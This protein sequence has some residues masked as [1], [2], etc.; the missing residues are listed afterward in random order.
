M[1]TLIFTIVA[2]L[3]SS[4]SV[5]ALGGQDILVDDLPLQERYDFDVAATDDGILFAVC[6]GDETHTLLSIYRSADGGSKWTHWSDIAPVKPSAEFDDV[7]L[8]VTSG[9][10]GSLLVAWVEMGGLLPPTGSWLQVAKSEAVEESPVWSIQEVDYTSSFAMGSLAMSARAMNGVPDRVSLAWKIDTEIS[11]AKSLTAGSLWQAPLE[12]SS[13]TTG[14][15]NDLDVAADDLGVVHLT[16]GTVDSGS[17][18]GL[19]YYCRAVNNGS[20]VTSWGAPQLLGEFPPAFATKVAVAANPDG[21]GVVVAASSDDGLALVTS[22]NA[23]LSWS[24]LQEYPGLSR[25]DADWGAA[26]PFVGVDSDASSGLGIGRAVISPIAGFTGAWAAELMMADTKDGL[27][28]PRLAV[29]PSRGG[30]PMLACVNPLIGEL[31]DLRLWFDAA[32]RDVPGYGVPE[33]MFPYGTAGLDMTRAVLPG[34][35]DGDATLELVFSEAANSIDHTL[36]IYDPDVGA[37]TYSA[38]GMHPSADYA[39]LDVDGDD[40]LEIVYFGAG[41]TFLMARNGD[42]GTVP[43]YPVNLGL[44][45]DAGFISGGKVTDS[46][47]DD[48]VVSG[49]NTLWV[50]GPGGIPRP[51][52]PV[53]VLVSGDANGRVALG[54]VD[55]DGLIDLVAPFDAGIYVF[56]RDGLWIDR[57]ADGGAAPGSP[58]LHDFDGDQ[59]ME[60]AYPCADGTVNLIHFDNTSVNPNWPFDTGATGMPSQ[61]ALANVTAGSQP[62]LVFR[63]ADGVVHLI[64]P[65]GTVPTDWPRSLDPG[66]GA[67]D[68]IVAQLG[69]NGPSIAVGEATGWLRLL[70]EGDNQEG[71]ARDQTAPILA[72]VS[73][74]DIDGDGMMEMIIPSSRA[75]WILDMGVPDAA[76]MWPISGGNVGRTGCTSNI[77]ASAV[78]AEIPAAFELGAATPNPFNPATMI[79]FN[80][81]QDVDR[82]SLRIYDVAGRLV[83]RLLE[84]SVQAG[85]HQIMWRGQDE[86]GNEV[87]SGVYFYVLD[88]DNGRRSRSMVLVR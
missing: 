32:W 52:F 3:V 48:V 28:A 64:T 25:P 11:Y 69:T 17:D 34:N 8:E 83:S 58:S 31:N 15:F 55:G 86:R 9:S 2:L 75:M 23:G 78:P 27:P 76:G 56:S 19:I 30:Q 80:L 61:V 16:W 35:L 45:I 57:I 37:I 38:V 14:G 47:E 82:A 26:G 51:G 1:K 22:Q 39:L 74:A 63:D 59:Q 79:S 43:G 29:D 44:G 18:V 72:P 5:L 77:V 46:A 53:N 71:W 85:D 10:P 4:S 41:G 7:R 60:I 66:T 88:T 65:S 87:A 49:G 13:L 42:G 67:V 21:S 73:A 70:E 68:P 33:P 62:D 20:L 40:E 6:T 24:A 36:H 84:G 50:F 12:L 81:P 54:D